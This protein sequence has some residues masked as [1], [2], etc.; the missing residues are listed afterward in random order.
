MRLSDFTRRISRVV[1][2]DP[3]EI[4]LRF[5]LDDQELSV[6][7]LGYVIKDN[8][9]TIELMKKSGAAST[10]TKSLRQ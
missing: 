4:S 6:K 5:M 8:T 3:R 10:A 9:W 2:V 1:S 7:F